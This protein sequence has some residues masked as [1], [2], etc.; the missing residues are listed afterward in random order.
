M[1]SEQDLGLR[2]TIHADGSLS[3]N[4]FASWR[5]LRWFR[6]HPRLTVSWVSLP[7]APNL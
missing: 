4:C 5:D 6:Q 7:I 3:S 1:N 2:N